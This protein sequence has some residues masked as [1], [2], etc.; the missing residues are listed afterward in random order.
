MEGWNISSQIEAA[1]QVASVHIK[2]F[3]ENCAQSNW[4]LDE[5]DFMVKSRSTIIPVFYKVEPHPI[6]GFADFV[7]QFIKASG[8]L[9]L[10]LKVIGALLWEELLDRI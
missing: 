7:D 8:G 6:P 1:N 2:I 3:Y 10:S 4:C 5:L 9:P